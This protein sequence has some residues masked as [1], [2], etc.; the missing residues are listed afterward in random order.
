MTS[1]GNSLEIK[2]Y[3]LPL[4]T[5]YLKGGTTRN[6][7]GL[8]LGAV[9]GF[10]LGDN[11]K[12]FHF[13][14]ELFFRAISLT[15]VP[16]VFVSMV[17]GVISISDPLKMGRVALKTI[18]LYVITMAGAT[19]LA[20]ILSEGV[21]KLGK[22]VILHGFDLEH[23][24]VTIPEKF[25]F[26]SSLLNVVPKNIFDTFLS[27]NILQVIFLACIFGISLISTKEKSQTV[28]DFF[29]GLMPVV[30]KF[31]EL[32][33][34]LAPLGVFGLMAY[35]I[36][37]QGSSI[38]NALLVFVLVN[39]L[40]MVIFSV[41]AY[42]LGLKVF[43]NLNP[44][45]FFQ[46]MLNVQ[47]FA[48]STASSAATLPLNLRVAKEDLGLSK[49][50]SSFVLPLGSTINMNGLSIYMG[51]VTVFA[52]N[53]FGLE[54]TGWDFLTVVFTSTIAAIGCAGVPAAGLIVMPIVLG[55]IGVPLKIITVFAAVDRLIDMMC[56]V[57]NITGDTFVA[58]LI[59][60][61]TGNL[62]KSQYNK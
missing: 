53:I 40:I 48:F 1:L 45:P 24:A 34:R 21:F 52:A 23:S 32:V 46:K 41:F 15:V 58:V 37:T 10:F 25:S 43:A 57:L 3:K 19:F 9:T 28:I 62:D 4:F 59:G 42:G 14:G 5:K 44:L 55:S 20:I 8:I 36:G 56:T 50:I 2:R 26:S 30:F 17:C 47:A 11:A 13:L 38:L 27:G 7:L 61:T 16:V 39:F 22:G 54:L 12:I 33:M 18:S 49:S 6:L 60:K 29:N 31:V 35:S 51:T